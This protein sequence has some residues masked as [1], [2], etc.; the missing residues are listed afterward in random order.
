MIDHMVEDLNADLAA[1]KLRLPE[2]DQG[3][4]KAM[5]EYIRLAFERRDAAI[6]KKHGLEAAEEFHYIGPDLEME[7]YI[8]RH[9][10]AR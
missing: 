5:E 6:G 4:D 9:A 7:D 3:G 8:S 10:V 1:R 2:L